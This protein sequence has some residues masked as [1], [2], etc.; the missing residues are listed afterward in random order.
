MLREAIVKSPPDTLLLENIH[1][2]QSEYV[3]NMP[4]YVLHLIN[5]PKTFVIGP[6]MHSLSLCTNIGVLSASYQQWLKYIVYF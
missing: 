5:S 1:H 2:S 3:Q 4:Q 6:D